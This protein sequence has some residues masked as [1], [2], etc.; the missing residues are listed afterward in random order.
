MRR[1]LVRIVL[2]GFL[3]APAAHAQAATPAQ[4]DSLL[5][6]LVGHW[7]MTGTVRGQSATY[8]L[9]GTRVLQGRF[10]ELQMTDLHRPAE[11]EAR[12]FVGVDSA[13]AQYIAHWL[14]N[15]GAAYSIP[16]ATGTAIGDTL[17][18]MFAYPDGPFRDT[19]AY[20][21]STA[22]WHFRL[23]SQDSTGTWRLFAEYDVRPEP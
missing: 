18:L 1:T 9:R 14:D 17:R 20:R 19:F 7:R 11:Y 3:L 10:V 4:M 22:T 6:H 12:V 16:H 21:R 13:R 23:E 15:F 2:A 5:S 8:A